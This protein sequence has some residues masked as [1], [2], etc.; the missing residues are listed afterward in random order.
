M[1]VK[2][3]RPFPFQSQFI[4]ACEYFQCESIFNT[5]KQITYCKRFLKDRSCTINDL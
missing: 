3:M 5:V 2:N 4:L 1:E